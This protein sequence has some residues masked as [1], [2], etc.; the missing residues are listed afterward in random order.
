VECEALLARRQV[1]GDGFG[2]RALP[3][4]LHVVRSS[5]GGNAWDRNVR[6]RGETSLRRGL[7][8]GAKLRRLHLCGSAP[9]GEATTS[10][11]RRFEES[12]V[13][14]QS[15][16][17]THKACVSLSRER[18]RP[19]SHSSDVLELAIDTARRSH[20]SRPVRR[21]GAQLEL[22]LRPRSGWG[23]R[24]PGAGRKPGAH[25]PVPHRP[26]G[27]VAERCPM[28]VT[29][30]VRPGLPSLR[31]VA[32]VHEV[33]RS[34][35]AACDRGDFRLVHYSL[36]SNHAHLIIE[37]ADAS[38]LARGMKA[39]GSRQS[40]EPRP[41]PPRVGRARAFPPPSAADAARGSA[42]AGLRSPERAPSRD[43][44][45]S[46]TR[47]RCSVVGPLV[48]WM[49]AYRPTD[50]QRLRSRC[51]GHGSHLAAPGRL[52]TSRI[53]RPR[54][55]AGR[56]TGADHGFKP[57]SSNGECPRGPSPTGTVSMRRLWR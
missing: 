18:P 43:A 26:R 7:E 9:S 24:R 28:H 23:G 6:R 56:C 50:R 17:G 41:R 20:Y 52:A 35:R 38:A 5:G 47:H 49:A 15:R 32:L 21:N 54:R 46:C 14:I 48:R 4:T 22:T 45:R 27:G 11:H 1:R 19:W 39:V 29:L 8:S 13:C 16:A 40:R 25:P 44:A 2:G 53:D 12:P 31:M 10:R 34:F 57:C 33:E 30:K 3:S 51:G 55:T 37:A 36:L 42:C